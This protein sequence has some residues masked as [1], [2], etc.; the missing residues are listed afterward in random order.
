MRLYQ[1]FRDELDQPLD[2]Q[3]VFAGMR[4]M[5]ASLHSHRTPQMCCV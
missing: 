4:E 5:R 1:E 3:E 2:P